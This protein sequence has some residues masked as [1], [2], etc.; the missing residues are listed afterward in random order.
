MLVLATIRYVFWEGH[1][2]LRNLHLTFDW[3]Y[4][5]RTKVRWRFRKILWPSQN[6][7]TLWWCK[8]Y[9]INILTPMWPAKKA[10]WRG[11]VDSSLLLHNF[12]EILYY[13]KSNNEDLRAWLFRKEYDF[14]FSSILARC[15]KYFHISL[16]FY[17]VGC[18]CYFIKFLTPLWPAKKAFWRGNVDSSS[19]LY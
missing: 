19:L 3:H 7:W 12:E 1:K 9:F 17:R 8:C 14:L 13:I 16:F 11:N 18:K 2:I 6:I 10:F 5:S 4:I 15:F